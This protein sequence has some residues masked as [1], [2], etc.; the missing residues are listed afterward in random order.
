MTGLTT[1]SAIIVAALVFGCPVLCA[2]ETARPETTKKSRSAQ[3]KQ[4]APT[5]SLAL[6]SFDERLRVRVDGIDYDSYRS[7]LLTFLALGLA[8]PV[9]RLT[10]ERLWID[11][12]AS[13]GAGPTFNTG[14][15]HVPIREDVSLAFA[16]SRWLTLRA[17]L[18]LGLTIDATTSDPATSCITCATASK[19]SSSVAYPNAITHGHT[20]PAGPQNPPHPPRTLPHVSGGA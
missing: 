10:N 14:H 3:R 11:G 19:K 5:V 18:G 9:L 16:E 15:W 12:N 1:T 7:Q 2:A 17:G 6:G 20:R 4:W 8:H 13:L